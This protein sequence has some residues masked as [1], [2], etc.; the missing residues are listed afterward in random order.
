MRQR[1]DE[2]GGNVEISSGTGGT[3]V[4]ARLPLQ[5]EMANV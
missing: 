3:T 5:R 1:A 2:V 4:T